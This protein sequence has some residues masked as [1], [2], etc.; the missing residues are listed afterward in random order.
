MR[1]H[2]SRET[3]LEVAATRCE[4]DRDSLEQQR[5]WIKR[6]LWGTCYE[7]DETA[8]ISDGPLILVVVG[9]KISERPACLQR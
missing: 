1:S 2:A 7:S 6:G 8:G 9:S 3:E 5:D 4:R